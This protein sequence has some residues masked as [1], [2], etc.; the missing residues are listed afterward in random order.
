MGDDVKLS[1]APL[2]IKECV[3]RKS[4]EIKQLWILRFFFNAK[5][6]HFEAD[7]M[8]SSRAGDSKVLR[9][10]IGNMEN[11]MLD[12]LDGFSWYES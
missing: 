3:V 11:V 6:N 5:M 4:S 2:R 12:I 1:N 9:I 8:V 10:V 7:L